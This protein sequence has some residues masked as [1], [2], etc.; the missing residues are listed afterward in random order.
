METAAL[1]TLCVGHGGRLSS[2]RSPFPPLRTLRLLGPPGFCFSPA[3]CNSA[4]RMS[5]PGDRSRSRTKAEQSGRAHWACAT[6]EEGGLYTGKGFP[7]PGLD[8]FNKII[9]IQFGYCTL[10]EKIPVLSAI[11]KKYQI[12]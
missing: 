3:N 9:Y 12:K 5:L 1:C 11:H 6:L 8:D 4:C 10:K 2:C 7:A